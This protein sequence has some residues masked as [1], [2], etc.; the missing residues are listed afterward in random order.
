MTQIE[1]FV[2]ECSSRPVNLLLAMFADLSLRTDDLGAASISGLEA[3]VGNRARD[4]AG[5]KPEVP[6]SRRTRGA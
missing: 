6:S 2:A 4:S 5:C 1:A 3:A